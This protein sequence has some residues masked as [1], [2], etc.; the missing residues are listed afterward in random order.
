[1][2][3]WILIFDE[4]HSHP[5]CKEYYHLPSAVPGNQTMISHLNISSIPKNVDEFDLLGKWSIMFD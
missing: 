4:D 2:K 1:M 5:T 3:L